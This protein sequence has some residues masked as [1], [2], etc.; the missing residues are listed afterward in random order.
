MPEYLHPNRVDVP[1]LHRAVNAEIAARNRTRHL[2]DSPALKAISLSTIRRRI[3]EIDKFELLASREGLASAKNRLG[4]YGAGLQV[5]APLQRIEMD[6]WEIDLMSILATA[7]LDI[8]DLSLRDI[9]LGR[10]WICVAFDVATRSV[11]AIKLAKAPSVET[12]LATIWMVMRE[13]SAIARRLGC[14]SNWIQHGQPFNI[15]V[16][17]GPG[18]VHV[19]FKAALSDLG[20]GY[21]VMPAGVPK[22]RGRIERLF[23][24]FSTMLMPHL[25]GRTFSNPTDRGEYASEKFTVHTG[26]SITEALVRYTVDIYHNRPHKSLA[27]ECPN[28]AWKRLCGDFGWAP[29][30]SA[31]KLRHILGVKLERRLGRHGITVCE[32]NYHSEA[33][34]RFFQRC[35]SQVLDVRLDPENLGH[36]SA[37]IQDAW[38]SIPAVIDGMEGISVA[39]WE[40]AILEIRQRNRNASALNQDVIDR[41]FAR[42]REIDADQRAWRQLGPINVSAAEI[43]RAEAESFFGL[44]LK[45]EP[46]N[47]QVPDATNG[48]TDGGFLS[49]VVAPERRELPLPGRSK[50]E[51]REDVPSATQSWRFSDEED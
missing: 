26:E 22:L 16:D 25:T 49:G 51:S 46:E 8:S 50:T 45:P 41:A 6:E 42:I 34:G 19:D 3:S 5:D 24:T 48:Q 40:Q 36:I 9:P 43:R 15:V 30:P 39:A 17:N 1:E 33:L 2:A 14:E 29:P 35:G 18:F 32:V 13:K 23:G 27:Y 44:N 4:P 37:W 28:D 10:Y 20:I 11:L 21:E 7:G 47:R 12:S 31:H 38:H